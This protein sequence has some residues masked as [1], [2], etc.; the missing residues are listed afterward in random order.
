MVEMV[1]PAPVRSALNTA[2]LVAVTVTGS[3][4][5]VAQYWCYN[6]TPGFVPYAPRPGCDFGDTYG[7]A[8]ANVYQSLGMGFTTFDSSAGGLGGQHVR[9][10]Q[11]YGLTG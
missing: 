11:D 10:R 1:V 8:V 7:M 2:S 3:N 4:C 9:L 6:S 5:S